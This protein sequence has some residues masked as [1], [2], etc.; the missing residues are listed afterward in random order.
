MLCDILWQ[1]DQASTIIALFRNR[2]ALQQNKLVRY[3][4]HDARTITS[5]VVCALGTAVLHVFK[6][7][8]SRINQFMAFPTMNV[9]YHAYAA[10]VVLVLSAIKPFVK[11]VL[12]MHSVLVLCFYACD[13]FILLLLAYIT[14]QNANGLRLIAWHIC[15]SSCKDNDLSFKITHY[16]RIIS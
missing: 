2:N 4:Q 9:D 5:F 14:M 1:K 13:L 7:L 6:N 15:L 11:I 8:Q 10:S 3:L 16:A 12:F